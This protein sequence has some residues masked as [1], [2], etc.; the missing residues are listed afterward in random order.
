ME[1]VEYQG[2]KN[3]YRLE[4][5]KIELIITADVGPRLIRFGFIGEDNEFGE[6]EDML[7]LTGGDEWRIYGG[8][9]FWHAP[10]SKPRT[11]FPDNYP[12]T[13]EESGNIVRVIQP[14]ETTTG[15]SK[16][17]DIAIAD[18][19]PSVRVTHRLINENLWDV[20]LAA[21]ALS[22]MAKEGCA[23][24]PQPPRGKH[25]D[26]LLPVNSMTMWAY[27]DMSDPRWRWLEKYVILLQDPI[28]RKPQKVG[29]MTPDGWA[30]YIRNGH[31]FVKTFE[32]QPGRHYP[33]LGCSVEIFTNA[34]MLELETLG[35]VERVSPGGC[36]EH[37]ENW[38]LF[39]DVPSPESDSDV[40]KN[41]LPGI[42]E[43]FD[44]RNKQEKRK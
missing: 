14:V 13:V 1:Q 6:F 27:T 7:G 4:N 21:W 43:A 39:R 30:A 34:D 9:R 11:Y 42:Q 37:V 36:L 33:D 2:W 12:I 15:I 17:I 23:I 35:P 10:E 5:G 29:L 16:Q 28:A 19:S 24:V 31:M 40:D 8:H 26:S 38:F 25:E 41:V 18:D 44:M 22:V 20:E 3:C 32:F